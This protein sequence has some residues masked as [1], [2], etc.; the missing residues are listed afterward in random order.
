MQETT[1]KWTAPELPT[2]KKAY[3]EAYPQYCSTG[4]DEKPYP[5][6]IDSTNR[7][8]IDNQ[9][10]MVLLHGV[11]VVYKVPPYIPDTQTFDS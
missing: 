7:I 11:N 2:D 6:S 9:N 10:R 8:I 1:G 3:C 5:F 4:G